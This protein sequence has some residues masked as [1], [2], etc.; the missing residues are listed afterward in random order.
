[1]KIGIIGIG[2]LGALI[3]RYLSQDF[4]IIAYDQNYSAPLA[5]KMG[6]EWGEFDEICEQKIIIPIVP[7]SAFENVIREMAPKLKPGTLVIDVCSV[8]ILPSE[9]M[10]RYLPQHTQILATHPMFGPDSAKDTLFG[11]KVALCPIRIE[12]EILNNLK[13]YLANNSI[14]VIETTP[15][16]HDQEIAHSLVLTHFIGRALIDYDAKPLEIDT[17]GYRRLMKILKTVENDTWQLFID[18]NKYN[19]YAAEVRT[20]FLKALSNINEKVG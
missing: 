5:K 3:A 12:S 15:D 18:M 4:K 16:K 11:K 19:P 2:R 9:I 6:I 7:I 1:M 17:L 20:N 14:N 8:K 10:L 13:K